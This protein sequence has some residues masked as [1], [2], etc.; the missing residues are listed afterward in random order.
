MPLQILE[1]T[2][3]QHELA[4]AFADLGGATFALAYHGALTD[5]RLAPRVRRV[6]DL[7]TQLSA[8]DHPLHAGQQTNCQVTAVAA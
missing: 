6:R 8:L 4:F 1:R 2:Q 3:L 7:Y 5:D